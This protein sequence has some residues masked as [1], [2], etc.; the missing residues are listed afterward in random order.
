MWVRL[1]SDGETLPDLY[2]IGQT[3]GYSKDQLD[4]VPDGTNLGLGLRKPH[5]SGSP[6]GRGD[7]LGPGFRSRVR[8]FPGLEGGGTR[9][10]GHRR[11]HDP[12]HAG[13]GP[14]CRQGRRLRQCRVSA[15]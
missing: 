13:A 1:Q 2:A 14:A 12:G 6:E 5:G 3:V 4:I 7:G 9:R 15:G 10:T 8:L 11:G